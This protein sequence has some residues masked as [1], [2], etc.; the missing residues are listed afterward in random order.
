MKELCETKLCLGLQIE[1]DKNENEDVLDPEVPYL[2]VV[3]AIFY[4][5][6]YTRLDIFFRKFIC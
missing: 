6:Q 4:L 2:S 5:V 3:C 1:H